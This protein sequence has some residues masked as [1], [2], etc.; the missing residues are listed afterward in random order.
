MK[1]LLLLNNAYWPS[2]GGIE[3]SL[4]HLGEEAR[5]R[6]WKVKIIVSDIGVDKASE[7]RWFEQDSG[8]EIFRYPLKPLPGLGPL[9]FFL[10]YWSQKKLLRQLFKSDPTAKVVARFHLSVLACLASGFK[11][12]A[13][14]V[15]GA[16]NVQY[17]AGMSKSQLFWRPDI[18]L[19]RWLHGKYQK[20]ALQQSRVYVF[21]EQMRAQCDQLV[22]GLSCV[23]V[24]TKP[25]V[26]SA[27]FH[28]PTRIEK[29]KMREALSLPSNQRFIL[30]A[31][32]F[33]H[34]KGVDILIQSLLSLT[35][36]CGLVLVGE[37]VAEN[38]YREQ[39]R[40]LGLEDRV[41]IFPVSR[42]VE[43]YFKACDVF[44]M[45]SNY[46]PLGQTILE[47]LASGLPVAAFSKVAGVRTATEELGFDEFIAYA[48]EYSPEALAASIQVQLSIPREQSARQASLAVQRFSWGQLL[49]EL[50]ET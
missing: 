1:T 17:T 15:P 6:G 38:E 27:R 39:M 37:G 8:M 42:R 5:A 9:N 44:V 41:H 10:G 26:D 16:V 20:L 34:A 36:D 18:L 14:L 22:A 47:A 32:R 2:V 24:T 31:G 4:R 40:V 11:D 49:T 13:Y 48:D 28:M 29:S 19:K 50:T 23:I 30:F 3:N 21:S 46:E 45:S 35:R 7:N 43:D 33:V 25:G 12:V